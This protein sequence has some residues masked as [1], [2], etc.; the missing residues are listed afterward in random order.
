[1]LRQRCFFLLF[2]SIVCVGTNLE[3]EGDVVPSAITDY[4]KLFV[5][6]HDI[7]LKIFNYFFP[8]DHS[9]P[10]HFI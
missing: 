2:L 5:V 10:L 6:I 7:L 3:T 8:S 1:M 4:P 9:L